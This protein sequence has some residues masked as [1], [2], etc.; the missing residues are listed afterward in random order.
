MKKIRTGIRMT[1]LILL[2]VMIS[3]FVASCNNNIT[4]SVSP[5]PDIVFE[6]EDNLARGKT[7]SG[8]DPYNEDAA[9]QLAFDGNMNTKWSPRDRE[10]TFLEVDFGTKTEVNSVLVYLMGTPKYMFLQY[11]ADGEW[12]DIYGSFA[13]YSE[14]INEIQ[15]QRFDFTTIEAERIRL[16]VTEGHVSVAE[17]EAYKITESELKILYNSANPYV[18]KDFAEVQTQLNLGKV[19]L[20][21]A[22]PSYKKETAEEASLSVC[23]EA[24]FKNGVWNNMLD[25]RKVF[26]AELG[27]A[28]DADTSWN[29]RIGHGGQ[30]YSIKG[31]FGEA[32]PRQSMKLEWTDS[33][34]QTTAVSY[35]DH[36]SDQ[37]ET[38]SI[39]MQAG[40]Y[41]KEQN[42]PGETFYSPMLSYYYD[43]ENNA[44]STLNWAQQAYSP[45]V[46]QSDLL[47][48][49]N[50]RDMGEGVIE[51]TNMFTNFGDTVYDDLSV[52]WGAIRKETL[53]DHVVSNTSGGY[54]VKE[55]NWSQVIKV[56]DTGGWVA[57]CVD[58][59]NKEALAL[60]LVFGKNEVKT[61][62]TKEQWS[63]MIY[64][65]GLN[66]GD[67]IQNTVIR[68]RLMPGETFYYRYYM[69]IDTLGKVAEKAN[70][71][72]SSVEYGYKNFDEANT[73][74]IP[75]YLYYDEVSG[76]STL[77]SSAEEGATPVLYTYS[78]PVA[79]SVPLY[80]MRNKETGQQFIT[81]D[82]YTLG[83]HKAFTNPYGAEDSKY[84]RYNNRLLYE[85]AKGK[86]EYLGILGYVMQS[87][88]MSGEL[89][90]SL[91]ADIMTDRTF[92]P[93]SGSLDKLVAVRIPE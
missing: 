92:F 46:N 15:Q 50:V 62:G 13:Q 12:V 61:L 64:S 52:P 41:L 40:S 47:V 77:I 58:A 86:V 82:P 17:L 60:G 69:V 59:S 55:G 34:F 39:V 31:G 79:G 5:S 9:C 19:L 53:K 66:N 36:N 30:I 7:Y 76:V 33:V 16:K 43:A 89:N 27:N 73:S 20:G 29:I 65:Y 54:S 56:S 85:V 26:F 91:L 83:E 78:K 93:A 63:D 70:A 8:S 28:Q 22:F 88:E 80:L 67:F 72:A 11:Y 49:S 75:Y 44:F 2:T 14:R 10:D 42:L 84:D 57:N 37:L 87:S 48:Y 81:T 3:A 35:T 51:I 1:A 23:F 45:N 32:V 68:F 21:D 24:T 25:E 90:Y 74:L 6:P 4:P 18:A 71:L 38:T